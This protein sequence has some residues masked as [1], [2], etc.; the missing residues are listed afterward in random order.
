M[1]RL[2]IYSIYLYWIPLELQEPNSK[3]IG[4]TGFELKSSPVQSNTITGECYEC[5]LIRCKTQIEDRYGH[6]FQY[7]K[8]GSKQSNTDQGSRIN[9]AARLSVRGIMTSASTYTA[10][11]GPEKSNSL[12]RSQPDANIEVDI[13]WSI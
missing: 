11:D 9:G 1:P 13:D 6:L 3:R 2:T 8:A 7:C 12:C 5:A 4:W 10:A